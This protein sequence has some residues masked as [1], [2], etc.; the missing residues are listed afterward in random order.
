MHEVIRGSGTSDM[1]SFKC[2]RSRTSF[3]LQGLALAGEGMGMPAY[4]SP[5]QH[6]T[7]SSEYV[8]PNGF[9]LFLLKND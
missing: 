9:L 1:E 2:V 5:C 3:L 4:S 8:L 6:H 7:S